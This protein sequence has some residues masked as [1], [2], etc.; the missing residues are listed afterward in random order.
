MVAYGG[1]TSYGVITRISAF[2]SELLASLNI[3][4]GRMSLCIHPRSSH[5]CV[6]HIAAMES[7]T[8][9]GLLLLVELAICV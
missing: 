7:W 5:I 6:H 1:I 2:A 4:V 9:A 8:N 3:L